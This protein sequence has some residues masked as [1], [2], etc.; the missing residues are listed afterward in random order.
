MRI[1]EVL[2]KGAFPGEQLEQKF[3]KKRLVPGL[4]F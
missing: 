1:L 2:P 3:A 4:G